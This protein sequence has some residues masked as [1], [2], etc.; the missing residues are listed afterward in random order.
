MWPKY[1][2]ILNF[3]F[4]LTYPIYWWDLN[5]NTYGEESEFIY[6]PT[7]E[8]SVVCLKLSAHVIVGIL[9]CCDS[10]LIKTMVMGAIPFNE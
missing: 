10:S 2:D 6:H 9:L 5:P 1:K 4:R 3:D 7:N 8:L